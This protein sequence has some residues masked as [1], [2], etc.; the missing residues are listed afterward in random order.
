MLYAIHKV[1]Q[2]VTL[3]AYAHRR[4]HTYTLTQTHVDTHTDTLLH[5]Q[6]DRQ[7]HIYTHCTQRRARNVTYVYT[8]YKYHTYTGT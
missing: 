3:Y 7:T 1:Q 8:T 6:T 4:A 5:R 2:K